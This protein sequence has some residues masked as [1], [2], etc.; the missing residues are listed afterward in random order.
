[1]NTKINLLSTIL[2]LSTVVAC[3]KNAS[4]PGTDAAVSSDVAASLDVAASPDLAGAGDAGAGDTKSTALL[5]PPE[6]G[7]GVQIEMGT[8]LNAGEE[9]ERC[10]FYTVPA[11][12]LNVVDQ[13]IKFTAGSHHFIV[14]STPYKEIPTKT[15]RG[16]EVDTKGVFDCGTNG[17]TGDW[18]TIAFF[19]VSQNANGDSVFDKLPAGTALK[20]PGG[21]ILLV[22][23]HYVN[24]SDKPL[25]VTAAVNLLTIP[26]ADVK[27]EAGLLFFY[28]RFIRVPGKSEGTA[29]MRCPVRSDITILT[30]TSHMHRRGVGYQAAAV[31]PANPD[32]VVPLFQTMSWADVTVARFNPGKTVKDKQLIDFSCSYKNGGDQTVLQGLTVKDEM[33]VF[34]GLYYPR[35]LQT[36]LCSLT[37]DGVIGRFMGGLWVGNGSADGKATADCIRGSDIVATKRIFPA[38][39]G[40]SLSQCV[41]ASCPKISLQMSGVVRCW[42]TQ[43]LT[44]CGAMCVHAQDAGCKSC[45][46]STCG[47]ALTALSAATCQ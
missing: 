30:A 3:G 46:E 33:C 27:Q 19:A 18:D 10:R 1:M 35:H 47:T 34:T 41:I 5:A 12:G 42:A 21:S 25:D 4:T 38:D 44:A 29:R 9:T 8:M 15:I 7:K 13:Q 36:E 22:N 26:D 37:P 43:G 17:P 31:D 32:A 2:L 40:D 45:L 39:K 14:F 16:Q 6:P 23:T 24:A 28:N 11:A 20:I